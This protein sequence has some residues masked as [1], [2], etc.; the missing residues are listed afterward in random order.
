MKN[1]IF[2]AT[3]AILMLTASTFAQADRTEDERA[4]GMTLSLFGRSWESGDMSQ[5]G[6]TLAENAVQVSP[7]G[8][9]ITGRAAIQKHM[10]WVRD[11]PLK[12]AKISATM[13][14]YALTFSSA[15]TAVSTFK[16]VSVPEGSATGVA[17]R[18]TYTLARIGKQWKIAHFQSVMI[19][20]PPTRAK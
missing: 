18:L 12:G 6:E 17:E 13:S 3:I 19:T 2:L 10:Q 7:F 4:I 8:D 15:D 14:E 9:V 11:V 5:V 1:I 16:I 20:A